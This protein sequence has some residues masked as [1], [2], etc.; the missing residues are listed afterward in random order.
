MDGRVKNDLVKVYMYHA[1]S[2]Q[3]CLI[4]AS[5]YLKVLLHMYMLQYDNNKHCYANIYT[6]GLG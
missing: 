2:L 5:K 6:K 3:S 4:S 1:K